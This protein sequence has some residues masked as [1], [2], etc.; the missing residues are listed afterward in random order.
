M[1]AIMQNFPYMEKVNWPSVVGYWAAIHFRFY[2]LKK[3]WP[4]FLHPGAVYGDLTLPILEIHALHID[5]D[6]PKG[7]VVFG[8]NER[9]AS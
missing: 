8:A 3:Q 1:I 4:F 2:F 6:T 5:H 7:E 9:Y